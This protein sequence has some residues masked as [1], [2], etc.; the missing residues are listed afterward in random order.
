MVLVD[1]LVSDDAEDNIVMRVFLWASLSSMV[2]LTA[3]PNAAVVLFQHLTSIL[4]VIDPHY[5]LPKTEA[6]II[7]TS[8]DASNSGERPSCYG[9]LLQT[10]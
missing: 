8:Q 1:R 2:L 4:S 6:P 3:V 7:V 5:I 9:M 10:F